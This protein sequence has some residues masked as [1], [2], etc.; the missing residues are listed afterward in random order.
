MK[1]CASCKFMA[2]PRYRGDPST[3]V[4]IIHGNG[5]KRDSDGGRIE[6]AS[7][8]LLYEEYSDKE[9]KRELAYVTDGSGYAARLNVRPEFGCVLH[10]KA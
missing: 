4:R 1:T 9:L 2:A 5:P 3:C 8:R 10:E 7:G 6:D